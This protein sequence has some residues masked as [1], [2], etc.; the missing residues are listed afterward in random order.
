MMSEATS[1]RGS[2]SAT[3]RCARVRV[4][5]PPVE[6]WTTMSEDLRIRSSVRL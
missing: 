4:V 6:P 1:V 2:S 3:Q 5:R